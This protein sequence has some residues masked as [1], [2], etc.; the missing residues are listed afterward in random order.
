M[1]IPEAAIWLN[2]PF[3]RKEEAKRLGACWDPLTRRW[4]AVARDSNLGRLRALGF[5]PKN[6]ARG[7]AHKPQTSPTQ[8]QRPATVT[9]ALNP[10]VQRVPRA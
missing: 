6:V 10:P 8:S 4:F 9:K 3:E 1:R 7:A 2:V 5:L